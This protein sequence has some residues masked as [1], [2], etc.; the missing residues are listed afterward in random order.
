MVFLIGCLVKK[1]HNYQFSLPRDS[2]E[3]KVVR[4]CLACAAGLGLGSVTN[5]AQFLTFPINFYF[6][7]WISIAVAT[8]TQARQARLETVNT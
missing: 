8:V 1:I 6:F 5:A 7:M 2:T 3:F 4:V